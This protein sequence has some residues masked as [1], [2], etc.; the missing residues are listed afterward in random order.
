M[1]SGT[2]SMRFSAA[3]KAAVPI[4]A[5]TVWS[6]PILASTAAGLHV[7]AYQRFQHPGNSMHRTACQGIA[8][9]ALCFHLVARTGMT[10]YRRSPV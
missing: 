3:K 2:P 8:C 5:M 10:T 7:Q 1:C 9:I 4:G 6:M